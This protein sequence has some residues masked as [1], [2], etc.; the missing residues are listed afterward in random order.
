MDRLKA[1]FSICKRKANSWVFE[2][3]ADIFYPPACRLCDTFCRSLLCDH[4]Q[5]LLA[6]PDVIARCQHCFAWLDAPTRLC[7]QCVQ[8]PLI[9]APRACLFEP[10]HAA[11]RLRI[12]LARDS[13]HSL[14]K[15]VASLLVLLWGR[16]DWP[17]PDRIMPLT[18]GRAMREIAEEFACMMHRPLSWEFRYEWIAPFQ[19][20]PRRHREGM[21]HEQ[22]VLLLDPESALGDLRIAVRELKMA[23]V[24]KVYILSVFG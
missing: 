20:R 6:L 10:V 19:W 21:L 9:S 4:C 16:L 8:S 14:Q 18:R 5:E 3:L 15:M 13:D 23:F 24:E 7:R 11:Q 12:E 1:L 17:L 22:T 2:S